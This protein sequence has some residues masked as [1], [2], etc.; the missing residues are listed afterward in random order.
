[1][2]LAVGPLHR[3]PTVSLVQRV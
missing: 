1:M 3:V 2:A